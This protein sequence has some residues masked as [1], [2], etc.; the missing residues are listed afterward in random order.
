MKIARLLLLAVAL[1]GL[2]ACQSDILAPT[3][4][5]S[6]GYAGSGGQLSPAGTAPSTSEGYAGSGG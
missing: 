6:E 5:E 3:V 2:G 4:Q 1:V